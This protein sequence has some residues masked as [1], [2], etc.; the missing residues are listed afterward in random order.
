MPIGE[1]LKRH[2]HRQFLAWMAWFGMQWNRPTLSDHYLMLI[3]AEVRR[4]IAEHPRRVEMKDF[5]LE[6][7]TDDKAAAQPTREQ[8]AA[9]SKAR[10]LG[11]MTLPVKQEHNGG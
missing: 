4:T 1:C 3:A 7:R 11:K 6:F 5:K 2:T 8:A 10:W 9:F